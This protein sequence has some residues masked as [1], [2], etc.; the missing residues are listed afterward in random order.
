M[1]YNR[2]RRGREE[3]DEHDYKQSIMGEVERVYYGGAGS[4][5]PG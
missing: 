2:S 4:S 1:I 3:E 5:S